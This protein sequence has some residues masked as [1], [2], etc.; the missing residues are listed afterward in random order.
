MAVRE[1]GNGRLSGETRDYIDAAHV[2]V[3]RDPVRVVDAD[4]ATLEHAAV[5]RLHAG[6]AAIGTSNVGFARFERGSVSQSNAG[7]IVGKSVACDEVRTLVLASPVV[8]GEVHTLVDLRTAFAL[9]VGMA[10]GK[11]VITALGKLSR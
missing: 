9:G 7:I 10:L 11:A 3:G 8:R 5:R 6:H 2:S 1:N 4:S